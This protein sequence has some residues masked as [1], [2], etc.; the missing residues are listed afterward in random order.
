MN[1]DRIVQKRAKTLLKVPKKSMMSELPINTLLQQ[2]VM[3]EISSFT[4]QTKRW[5]ITLNN[6]S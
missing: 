6:G 4:K 2:K 5:Y 1:D 3:L